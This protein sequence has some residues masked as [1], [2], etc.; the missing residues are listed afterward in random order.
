MSM[1]LRGSK[2]FLVHRAEIHAN[3]TITDL[4]VIGNFETLRDIKDF[5]WASGCKGDWRHVY[6]CFKC[7]YKTNLFKR[8]HTIFALDEVSHCI[9]LKEKYVYKSL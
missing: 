3:K 6:L 1:L 5:A 4:K 8:L 2:M 7:R 9:R